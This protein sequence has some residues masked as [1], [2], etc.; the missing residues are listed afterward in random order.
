ML[1][2]F[3]NSKDNEENTFNNNVKIGKLLENYLDI[4][5][6]IYIP[7]KKE[8]NISFLNFYKYYKENLA[9]DIYN[10]VSNKYVEAK[11][12]KNNKQNKKYYYEYKSIN[13]DSN[14]LLEY[15]YIIESLTN[16]QKCKLFNIEINEINNYYIY[17]PINQQ[18]TSRTIFNSFEKYLIDSK[19]IEWPNVIILAIL[20]I[21][22]LSIRFTTLTPFTLTIYYLFQ[23]LAISARK[24]LEIIFSI[25]LRLLQKKGEPNYSIF[26][27][28]FNL[29]NFTI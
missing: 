1:T 22:S 23:N 18:I 13:L 27:K 2:K 21:V 15:S 12:N 19:Y 17:K 26:E 8:K 4:I 24:Y 25:C 11:I 9:L 10:L 14:L 28:Y 6:E 7:Q 29:Y 20:N 5:D 3:S 16:E